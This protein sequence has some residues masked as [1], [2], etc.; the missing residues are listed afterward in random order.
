MQGQKKVCLV[1]AGWQGLHV[2]RRTKDVCDL[3]VFDWN[4]EVGG[5]WNKVTTNESTDPNLKDNQFYQLY[6]NIPTTVFEHQLCNGPSWTHAYR[7]MMLPMDHDMHMGGDEFHGLHKQW[8]DKHDLARYVKQR[9]LVQSVRLTANLTVEEKAAT[10]LPADAFD[11]KFLVQWIS[12]DSGD[13]KYYDTFDTVIV[14]TGVCR[15]PYIPNI[16]GRESWDGVQEHSLNFRK[17][18]KE[19]YEG[20]NVLIVGSRVFAQE[21]I[22]FLLI[23]K[24]EGAT[25][26][27]VYITSTSNLSEP[28][29]HSF[30]LK[31]LIESGKLKI[32][33]DNLTSLKTG[34][35]ATFTKDDGSTYDLDID[36]IEWCTG[37]KQSFPFI[38]PNDDLIHLEANERYVTPLYQFLWCANDNDLII[39]G[40]HDNNLP[41]HLH[42]QWQTKALRYYLEGKLKMPSKENQLQWLKEKEDSL[43]ALDGIEKQHLLKWAWD[44]GYHTFSHSKDLYKLITDSG[45]EIER[46]AW[47]DDWMTMIACMIM[48]GVDTGNYLAYKYPDKYPPP[49]PIMELGFPKNVYDYEETF[50]QRGDLEMF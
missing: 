43:L 49:P 40:I 10:E 12:R 45:I 19:E 17:A 6:G 37:Y 50:Q 20:K 27:Q 41:V 9:T 2:I 11:R 31:D 29:S 22:G 21:M 23:D 32:I 48:Q 46:E 25:P 13:T 39:Q 44:K 33:D 30:V 14:S 1:G 4:D 7:D 5:M 42:C 24:Y 28:F 36:H 16:Q 3:T 26:N 8:A 38:D 15:S 47:W 35:K 34:S 18:S